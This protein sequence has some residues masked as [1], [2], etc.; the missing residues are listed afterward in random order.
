MISRIASSVARF[1]RTSAATRVFLSRGA[2]CGLGSKWMGTHT[3]KTTPLSE[4]FWNMVRVIEP[5]ACW[6]FLGTS[7]RYGY[8][9]IRLGGR[10]SDSVL[11]HRL[12]FE[13]QKGPIPKGSVV[14]HVCDQPLCCN[15]S[16]LV[17]GTVADNNR[18]MSERGQQVR[19]ERQGSS[20]LSEEL[21]R[22]IRKDTR[23]QSEIARTYGISQTTV[24]RIKSR[25]RWKH[26]P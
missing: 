22:S 2:G 23:S 11:A 19:G 5:E 25:E 12:A 7:N 18:D 6:L 4:R 14:R 1:N 20:K 17:L 24:H 15:G 10:G 21:V 8:G 16:H 3:R 13:L 26:V 9:K